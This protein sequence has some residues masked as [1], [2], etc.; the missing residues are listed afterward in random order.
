MSFPC[1]PSWPS[2]LRASAIRRS[3]ARTGWGQT[4]DRH[5]CSDYYCAIPK[6]DIL[7]GAMWTRNSRVEEA[8]LQ[9]DLMLFDPQTAKF[10]VLNGTMAFVWRNCNGKSLNQI[11]E[12]MEDEFSGV[13]RRQ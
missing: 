13:D 3:R 4:L 2:C 10:Y 5:R 8:P 11:A 6:D 12:S 7:T 9:N 1:P